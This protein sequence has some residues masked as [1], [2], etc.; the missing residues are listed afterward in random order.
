MPMTTEMWLGMLAIPVGLALSMY[1]LTPR[2][3]V[4]RA[5]GQAAR[6]HRWFQ[7][8]LQHLGLIT[9]KGLSPMSRL[10]LLMGCMAYLSSPLWLA[11]LMVGLFIQMF[12][13]VDWSSFFYILNPQFTPFMLASFPAGLVIYWSWNNL[14]TIGQ[15]WLIMRQTTLDK[16]QA[17]RV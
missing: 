14:L 2:M 7:G 15:Q 1:G 5:S 6:D 3:D 9:A 8:N 17:A 4:L 16:P 13:P 10:Q 11:S 12:Y